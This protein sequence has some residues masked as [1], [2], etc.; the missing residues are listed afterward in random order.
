M[1][2]MALKGKVAHVKIPVTNYNIHPESFSQYVD[3]YILCKHYSITLE[4]L[5]SDIRGHPQESSIVWQLLRKKIYHSARTCIALVCWAVKNGVTRKGLFDEMADNR[6][7]FMPGILF[8]WP[9]IAFFLLIPR[10]ISNVLYTK[11]RPLY[12]KKY[13]TFNA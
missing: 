2:K 5:A 12:S 1:N 8:A 3:Y 11:V 9:A 4:I 6:S 13:W 10:Q 7:M